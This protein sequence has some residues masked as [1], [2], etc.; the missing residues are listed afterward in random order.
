MHIAA[1]GAMPLAGSSG[2]RMKALLYILAGFI[3][4]L[5]FHEARALE[6]EPWRTELVLEQGETY[7]GALAVSN[8]RGVPV[9]LDVSFRDTSIAGQGDDWI[10]V[11]TN[12][13]ALKPGETG[14]VPYR[15]LVPAGAR[16]E[17]VGRVGFMEQEDGAPA[18]VSVRTKISVP[19]YA[20]IDGTQ[21][22]GAFIESL[23]V[24]ETEPL[25]I[26]ISVQNE[27]NVHLRARGEAVVLKRGK[28]EVCATFPVNDQ[29]FPVY[30]QRRT[31]IV[32]SLQQELE[33]GPYE[34][35]VHLPFPD[36]GHVLEKAAFFEVEQKDE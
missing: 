23:D 1:R 24:Q 3:A 25:K 2:K 14:L 21:E 10:T 8:D 7:E 30:P 11:A 16:G 33:P 26:R 15:I 32:G 34:V 5:C 9:R 17:F 35:R 28:D 19:I 6:I 13:L 4:V 20:V 31:D 12:E 18:A 29:G 36:D 22:Y 27:G